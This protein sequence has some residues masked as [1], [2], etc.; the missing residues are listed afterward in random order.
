MFT[1]TIA[2]EPRCI[3]ALVVRLAQLA[4]HPIPTLPIINTPQV[5]TLNG[6]GA[7]K[8]ICV[9]AKAL[10]SELGSPKDCR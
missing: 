7:Y 3:L 5:M 9:D 1:T 4:I 6:A 8:A 2:L 10:D